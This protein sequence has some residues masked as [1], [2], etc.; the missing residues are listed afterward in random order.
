MITVYTTPSCPQCTATM[1]HLD[2]AHMPYSVVDVTA[3]ADAE[4]WLRDL[5]YETAPVV[6]VETP[7]GIEH[8][9]SYRRDRIDEVVAQH[10]TV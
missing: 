5:G 9:D 3:N 10:R 2:K 1:T 8:W 4:Q 6:T 7:E